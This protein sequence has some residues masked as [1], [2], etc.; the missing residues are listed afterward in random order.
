MTDKDVLFRLNVIIGLLVCV[1]AIQLFSVLPFGL[2]AFVLALAL[3]FVPGLLLLLR[4][5]ESASA[6]R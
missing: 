3:L 4:H 1:L 6:V 5:S 2:L